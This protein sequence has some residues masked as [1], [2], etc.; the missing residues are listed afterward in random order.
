MELQENT[1][2]KNVGVNGS[3]SYLALEVVYMVRDRTALT[4]LVL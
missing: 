4:N 3:L 1:K 2:F